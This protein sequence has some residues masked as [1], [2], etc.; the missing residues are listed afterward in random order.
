MAGE[1]FYEE[2][3]LHDGL[4]RHAGAALETIA[5]EVIRDVRGFLGDRPL[6]DDVTLL[7]VRRE[8]AA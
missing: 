7:L 2:R 1:E 4:R 5:E 3:R 6:T 8:R